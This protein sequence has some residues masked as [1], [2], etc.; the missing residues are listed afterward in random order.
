MIFLWT[1]S[2]V[3]TVT[4]KK[5]INM[6]NVYEESIKGALTKVYESIALTGCPTPEQLKFIEMF[7]PKPK[8]RTLDDDI[9]TAE[10][11]FALVFGTDLGGKK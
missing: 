7:K 9:K 6:N 8:A 2:D 10:K 4:R 1:A 5:G 3:P 11:M